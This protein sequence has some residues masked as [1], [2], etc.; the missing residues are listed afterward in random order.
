MRQR[1]WLLTAQCIALAALLLP[2]AAC[3]PGKQ[4]TGSKGEKV[5]FAMYDGSVIQDNS[6][7]AT[8]EEKWETVSTTSTVAGSEGVPAETRIE[9]KLIKGDFC[10]IKEGEVKCSIIYEKGCDSKV[11]AA[12][13]DLA[14]SLE[15]MTGKAFTVI[16]ADEDTVLPTGNKIFVGKSRYTEALGVKVPT[17]YPNNEGFAV[18][19]SLNIMVLAGND[20]KYYNGTA[21]AVTYFLESLGF[22]W[23]ANDELWNVVPHADTVFAPSCNYLSKPTFP[24]RYNRVALGDES[25]NPVIAKRWFLGGE[26]SEVDHKFGTFFK[27]TDFGMENEV[28]ALVNNS[29]SIEGKVWWQVCLSNP[30]VQQH[31]IECVRKFFRENPEYTGI[32]IGQN[33]GNGGI[34]DPDYGNFCECDNCKQFGC[35]FTVQMVKFANIVARAVKDEFP[36]KTLMI[37]SYESTFNAP[38]PEELG[39]K[40]EDNVQITICHQGGTTRTIR[41]GDS[42]DE[43][44]NLTV[45]KRCGTLYTDGRM[46]PTAIFKDN[47][48]NWKA[49]GGQRALYEWHC[50]GAAGDNEWRYRFWVPGKAFIDN[51]RWLKANGCRFIY[52]DQ[53]PNGN[54]ESND[55]DCYELRWPLWYVSAKAM[56]NCNQSFKD[57]MMPA[58][59]KLYGDAGEVMFEFYEA[60]ADANDSC[61]VFCFEWTL[62]SG[63][64]MY[65]SSVKKIDSIMARARKQAD[66]IG[67]DVKERVEN[68]YSYWKMTKAHSGL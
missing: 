10:I 36:D 25:S 53:G 45:S 24:T 21:F 31:V 9:Y 52:I 15:T 28:Y 64:E 39:E 14:D 67:G 54:Y 18:V 29:R 33:D 20:E 50:A 2:S 22:G 59:K 55:F 19:S 17:G 46:L 8:D 41:K 5:V 1:K 26:P 66:A 32:S 58:C 11:Y 37:Y 47:W 3:T 12:V 43:S 51:A 42:F 23:F 49:L 63:A 65:G 56:W 44:V 7:A 13:W 68:Q 34:G 62:P 6:A 4:E 60:L 61:D 27:A 48:L 16:E 38:T 30:K 40:I 57:I 35:S